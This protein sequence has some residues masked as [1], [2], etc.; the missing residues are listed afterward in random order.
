M[1][2]YWLGFDPEE[3]KYKVLSTR[4]NISKQYLKHW[5]FTLEID[6]SWRETQSTPSPAMCKQGV[7]INGVIYRFV[8]H[9]GIAINAF[10]VKTE[11]SKLIAWK[12]SKWYDYELIEVKGQLAV[13]D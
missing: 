3:N 6:E 12:A 5:I 2:Y 4:D 7:C 13:I 9:D 8:Y 1:L 11:S 10:D